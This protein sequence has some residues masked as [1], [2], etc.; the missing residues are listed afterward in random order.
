MCRLGGHLGP[1]RE[2]PGSGAERTLHLE[3]RGR[4]GRKW[5]LKSVNSTVL[6]VLRSKLS[7]KILAVLVLA[8]LRSKLSAKI[9]AVLVLASLR[10]K[11][12]AKIRADTS[13]W[14]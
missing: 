5:Q 2:K 14:L 13:A 11:L 3:Q 6:A 9:L 4:N 7:A 12:S 1:C 10:S 8:V